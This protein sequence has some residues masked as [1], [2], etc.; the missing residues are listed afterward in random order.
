VRTT[1]EV[2]KWCD[3]LDEFRA[4]WIG[5]GRPQPMEL[6]TGTVHLRVGGPGESCIVVFAP[7]AFSMRDVLGALGLDAGSAA[8]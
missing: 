3:T 5:L 8:A 6:S 1:I 2:S 4:E 7:T